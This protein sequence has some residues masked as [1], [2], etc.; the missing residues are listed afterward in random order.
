MI[1]GEQAGEMEEVT[2]EQ[3]DKDI[4]FKKG[5]LLAHKINFS[6]PVVENMFSK[7]D[8]QFPKSA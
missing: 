3:E 5:V 6:N 8:L 4:N 7:E 2:I 1:L